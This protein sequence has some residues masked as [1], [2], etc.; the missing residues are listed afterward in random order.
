MDIGII[1]ATGNM[2]SAWFERRSV[3]VIG[4]QGSRETQRN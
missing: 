3:A 4:S 2:D 1:G